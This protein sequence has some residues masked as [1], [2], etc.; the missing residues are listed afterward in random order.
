MTE[1]EL[2]QEAFEEIVMS[3]D[4]TSRV[5]APPNRLH[6]AGDVVIIH[7]KSENNRSGRWMAAQIH[8]MDWEEDAKQILVL[9][10]N[11]THREVEHST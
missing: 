6:S 4:E 10:F 3:K 2:S 8:C 1:I 9:S 11:A 5:E 7:E